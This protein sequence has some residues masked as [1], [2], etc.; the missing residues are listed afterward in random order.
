MDVGGIKKIM[1]KIRKKF[2]IN[3]G[4]LASYLGIKEVVISRLKKGAE[5]LTKPQVQ[6]LL[7][8][9]QFY[10]ME[11]PL[12]LKFDYVRIRF[13]T[14]DLESIV[15]SVLEIDLE[16]L[17]AEEYGW[18]GYKN[19]IA[20]GEIIIMYDIEDPKMG[21]LL[22]LKGQGCRQFEQILE[23]Q[24]RSWHDFFVRAKAHNMFVKR[25][26]IAIDDKSGIV[27][28]PFFVEKMKNEECDTLFRSY[29]VYMNSKTSNLDD[30]DD[31]NN[32]IKVEKHFGKQLGMGST[33]YIGS[34][35]SNIYFTIYEKDYEQF[36]K[37]GRVY[38][39]GD[40]KNRF[41]IRL[42]D[43]RAIKAIESYIDF[44]NLENLTYGIINR[45]L[46]FKDKKQ[47]F[48]LKDC[49]VNKRW[50]IFMHNIEHEIR[51]TVKPEEITLE[52]QWEWYTKQVAPT[53]KMLEYHDYERARMTVKEAKLSVKQENVI[54][55][56]G[57]EIK[58]LLV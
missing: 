20:Y 22:E 54:R 52:R 25:V 56:L 41:E 11:N 28:I 4:E 50:E 47:S 17:E 38:Q 15:K 35:K 34:R 58:E 3:Q 18:Y 40:P 7:N 29:D 32:E 9:E 2:G 33:L 24:E 27:D 1:L 21:V 39:K 49:P 57:K 10:E 5:Q 12:E 8:L 46:S 31:G 30:S 19:H 6:Q 36:V 16:F 55:S 51:L 13:E 48:K 45:Y 42:K 43:E 53:A 26:D 44:D 14:I 37:F 23:L